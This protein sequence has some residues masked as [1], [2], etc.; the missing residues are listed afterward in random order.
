M[1]SLNEY[2]VKKKIDYQF[3]WNNVRSNITNIIFEVRNFTIIQFHIHARL[4]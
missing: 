1:S 4:N 2:Q 3:Y